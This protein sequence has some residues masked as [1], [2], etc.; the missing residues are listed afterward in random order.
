ML[1]FAAGHDGG[2]TDWAVGPPC[3]RVA[4]SFRSSWPNGYREAFGGSKF[5]YSLSSILEPDC[6]SATRPGRQ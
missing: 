3:V 2:R 6:D 1:V 4:V 5:D